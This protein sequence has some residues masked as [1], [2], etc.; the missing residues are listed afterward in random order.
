MPNTKLVPSLLFGV[1][2]AG[3]KTAA[4][5]A[6]VATPANAP[7]AAS[8]SNGTQQLDAAAEPVLKPASV[9]AEAWG[10]SLVVASPMRWVADLDALSTSLHLPMPLGQSFL[11]VL[12]GGLSPGGVKVSRETIDHL[13]VAR[14]VAVI[15]LARGSGVPAGWCAAVA[16]KQRAFALEAL[17]KI[18]TGTAQGEGTFERRLP[19]GDRVWGAVKDRQLLLSGS[20]ETLLAAGALAITAQ[21]TPMPVQA[22]FTLSPSVMARSTGQSLEAIAA[23]ILSGAMAEAEKD[24]S[25]T[26]KPLTSAHKKM[27]EALLKALIRQLTDIAV[28]RVSLEIGDRD[29]LVVRA[30]AQPTP[31]SGLA[32]KAAH[33]SPYAFDPALPVRSDAS[34]IVAW[35]DMAPWLADWIQVMEASGPAGQA[36][37]RDLA[38]LR[39]SEDGGS[40]A[41]DVRVLPI[42]FM[43]S[44]TVRPGVDASRAVD[45]YVAFLQSSNLWEAEIDGR[46]AKPVKVKRAGKVVEIE[47]TVEGKDPQ[48][49]AVLKALMGGDVAR[50]ALTVKDGRVVLAVGTK[51]REILDHYGKQQPIDT[52]APILARTLLDTAGADFLGLVDGASVLT[53]IYGKMQMT[54]KDLGNMSLTGMLAAVPGLAD[55][56][57]PV[58]LSGRGGKAP[59]IEFQ[60]PFGSLQNVARV[61]SAFMGQMGVAPGR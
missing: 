11:P 45:R 2:L 27:Q 17:Q 60:V 33:V 13:D 21:T 35:G 50:T 1:A 5:A 37:S 43:C 57:V 54:G 38:L 18:G 41:V 39:E 59:A 3:C 61:V 19:S 53:S 42:L 16:F 7:L 56:R 30:E 15:W 44:L 32:A 22:I 29:G 14:P 28:V 12:T 58:V 51:P 6:P 25:A 31:G 55:L 20:R 40:C 49:M 52:A 24:A 26:G 10:M 8:P 48:A 4:P 23:I 47:K 36:A 46:K 34:A 9:A